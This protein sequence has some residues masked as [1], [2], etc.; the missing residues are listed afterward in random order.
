MKNYMVSQKKR[1]ELDKWFEGCR[2]QQDPGE[3]FIFSWIDNYAQK[4]KHDWANSLCSKCINSV[5][6]GYKVA[7]SCDSFKHHK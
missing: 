1:I 2:I 6:C 4:F 5:G 3:E 7:Q